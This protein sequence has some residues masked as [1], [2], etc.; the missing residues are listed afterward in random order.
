[1]NIHYI[2][3]FFDAD[4]YLTMSKQSNEEKIPCAGFTNNVREILEEIQKF[5]FENFSIKG[6]ICKKPARKETHQDS[7]DLKY[8]GF[9]T[10]GILKNVLCLKHPKK[11]ARFEILQSIHDL[12]YRNGKYSEQML[13]DRRSRCE[14]FFNIL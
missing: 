9:K 6:Y 4:G 7:Y 5:L 14:D 8:A 3:G 11:I 2:S 12:T 13:K 1:M 10:C